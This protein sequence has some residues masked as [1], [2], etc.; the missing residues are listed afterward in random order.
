M[1]SL[2]SS[3]FMSGIFNR[4]KVLDYQCFDGY[5]EMNDPLLGMQKYIQLKPGCDGKIEASEDF[6]G[7]FVI[8]VS[9]TQ[10][11]HPV[12]RALR[13]SYNGE[14][15]AGVDNSKIYLVMIINGVPSIPNLA[16]LNRAYS[17]QTG[18][19]VNTPVTNFSMPIVSNNVRNV[20]NPVNAIANAINGNAR[21]NT[22]V[23]GRRR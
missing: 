22:Q 21:V 23:I 16:Q 18:I 4:G 5:L 15:L 20:L 7:G 8:L 9:V 19:P 11:S 13:L 12:S 1:T 14:S 17:R 10:D 6:N 2:F 3:S